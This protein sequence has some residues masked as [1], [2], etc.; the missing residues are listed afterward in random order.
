M[1]DFTPE[2]LASAEDR[3]REFKAPKPWDELKWK[4][5]KAAMA[6]AN[7][8]DGGLIILGVEEG[9]TGPTAT[10]LSNADLQTYRDDEIL[11]FINRFADPYVRA[12]IHRVSVN[13][14]NFVVIEV[15]EFDEQPVVCKR[16]G[17]E[18]IREG[19][20]YVRSRQRSETCAVRSQTEIRELLD[21]AIERGVRR[22]ARIASGAGLAIHPE[23]DDQQNFDAQL[24]RFVS[25]VEDHVPAAHWRIQ[26]RPH[27]FEQDRISPLPDLWSLVDRCHVRHY[28]WSVPKYSHDDR[29]H[30]QDYIGWPASGNY[31]ERWRC[32]QSGLFAQVVGLMSDHDGN[33][34]D[35]I[36]SFV[37]RQL[38][39]QEISPPGMVDIED[40]IIRTAITYEFAARMA[41]AGIDEEN[42]M[43]VAFELRGI[44][45]RVLATTNPRRSFPILHIANE[46]TLAF[47]GEHGEADLIGSPRDLACDAA[48]HLFHRFGWED[49]DPRVIRDA[50]DG[51]LGA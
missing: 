35:K 48:I 14:R 33:W 45:N 22:F 3:H 11:S 43:H 34:V 41:A 23:V 4:V 10:G 6:M 50:Q 13:G 51:I 42:S 39:R 37:R 8:R 1:N 15:D 32:Y 25:D 26:I 17:D 29:A 46:D 5:A 24:T 12:S 27:N 38:Q 30:G 44:K 18:D 36:D 31:D 20:I 9:S 28:G 21:I 49:P 7:K 2:I 47:E 19:A 40:V 16:N